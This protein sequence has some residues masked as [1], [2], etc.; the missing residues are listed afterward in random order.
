[1]KS[2]CFQTNKFPQNQLQQVVTTSK[3]LERVI[4][5]VN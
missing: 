4:K 3:R 5:S 2:Q 1:M